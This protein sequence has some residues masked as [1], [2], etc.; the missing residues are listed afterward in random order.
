MNQ[1]LMTTGTETDLDGMDMFRSLNRIKF[2]E[3]K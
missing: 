3:R 1:Q 2:G